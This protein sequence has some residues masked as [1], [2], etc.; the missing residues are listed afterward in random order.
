MNWKESFCEACAA[1]MV[2]LRYSGCRRL[3]EILLRLTDL[4]S[5][6]SV[7]SASTWRYSGMMLED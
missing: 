6:R 4:N 5:I 2:A 1:A 7:M 3:L